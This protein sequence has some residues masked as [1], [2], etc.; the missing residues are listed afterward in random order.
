MD[1]KSA[2]IRDV[3]ERPLFALI[4]LLLGFTGG[5]F[6]ALWTVPVIAALMSSAITV[7]KLIGVATFAGAV[8]SYLIWPNG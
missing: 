6:V 2:I 4:I 5:L 3:K 1:K 7:T 8:L